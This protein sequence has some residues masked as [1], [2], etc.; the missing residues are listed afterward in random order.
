MNLVEINPRQD[1]FLWAL[2]QRAT[3]TNKELKVYSVRPQEWIIMLNPDELSFEAVPITSGNESMSVGGLGLSIPV[4]HAEVVLNFIAE[5]LQVSI[6]ELQTF[7]DQ[8]LIPAGIIG[9]PFAISLLPSSTT[10]N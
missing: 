2:A 9:G 10:E 8:K 5:S 7:L 1:R 3:Q 4:A 6:D